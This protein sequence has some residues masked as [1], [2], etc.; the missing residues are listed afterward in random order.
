MKVTALSYPLQFYLDF[1]LSELSFESLYF[2]ICFVNSALEVARLEFRSAMRALLI[3]ALHLRNR[4]FHPFVAA[5]A[6]K[7]E[8]FCIEET[9]HSSFFL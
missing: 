2:T 6:G 1:D 5:R 7:F 9:T 8:R 4:G 3:N